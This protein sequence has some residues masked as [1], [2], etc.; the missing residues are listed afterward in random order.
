MKFSIFNFQFSKKQGGFTLIELLIVI[1]IIGILSTLLTTN[2][3]GVRQR[4]RDGKRKADL[5]QIQA[6]LE[7]Y[8]A[9]QGAYPAT[10][11]SCTTAPPA[12]QNASQTTTYM[13]KIPCDPLGASGF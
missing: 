8:R 4:A 6:A 13:Q 1:A 2:F 12:F 11:P 9:D 5:S 3:I 7:Q 10:L